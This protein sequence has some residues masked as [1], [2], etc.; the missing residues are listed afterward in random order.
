MDH[1]CGLS[2]IFSNLICPSLL[3]VNTHGSF[4]RK[5]GMLLVNMS[6]SLHCTTSGVYK[7]ESTESTT[8]C[9]Y[10]ENNT[11]LLPQKQE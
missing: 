11:R 6:S 7:T 8:F 4:H 2:V 5:Q 1:K 10:M 9:Q 3:L